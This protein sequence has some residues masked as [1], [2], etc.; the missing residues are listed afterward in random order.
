MCRSQWPRGLGSWFAAARPLRSWVRILPGVLKSVSCECCV[1]PGASGW[2]LV[3]R[4]PTECGVSKCGLETT[5]VGSPWPTGDCCAMRKEG[6]CV[7]I[8]Y[9]SISFTLWLFFI[10]SKDV[11][12]ASSHISMRLK[13]L[14]HT[15]E[16]FH[17]TKALNFHIYFSTALYLKNKNCWFQDVFYVSYSSLVRVRFKTSLRAYS[18]FFLKLQHMPQ[19]ICCNFVQF[20]ARN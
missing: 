12:F 6:T 15:S 2:S 1:L 7:T 8:I 18:W 9:S 16:S 11:W 17:H 4:S 19:T 13:E 5:S 14:D 20:Q 3:H 10:V